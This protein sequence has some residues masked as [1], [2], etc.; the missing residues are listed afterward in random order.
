MQSYGSYSR[1]QTKVTARA[2]GRQP[3]GF[4]PTQSWVAREFS[5]VAPARESEPSARERAALTRS[6]ENEHG[7]GCAHPGSEGTPDHAPGAVPTSPKSTIPLAAQQLRD[8]RRVLAERLSILTRHPI[9]LEENFKLGAL[10]HGDD[11]YTIAFLSQEIELAAD[12]AAQASGSSP[13]G[14]I[15]C[16]THG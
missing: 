4:D 10:S 2:E 5:P 3:A 12:Q 1:G 13:G 8:F 16:H 15:L 14:H 11:E 6:G 9:S 7:A